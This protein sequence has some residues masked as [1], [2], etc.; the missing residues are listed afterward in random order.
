MF[1]NIL[2]WRI[3][4]REIFFIGKE[5]DFYI[6]E[7]YSV[8]CIYLFFFCMYIFRYILLDIFE[9]DKNGKNYIC[10]EVGWVYFGF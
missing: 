10:I 5:Y 2:D 9:I 6:L 7:R 4:L 1:Y 3:G 8:K